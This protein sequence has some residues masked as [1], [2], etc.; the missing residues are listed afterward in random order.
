MELFLNITKKIKQII[1]LLRK[2]WHQIRQLDLIFAY[3]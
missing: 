2:V 1:L 3:F